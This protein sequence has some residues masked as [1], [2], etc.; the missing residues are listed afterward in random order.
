MKQKKYSSYDKEFYAIVQA[1]KKWRN[2]LMPKEF[3]LYTNNSAL[4]FISSQPKLNQIHAKWVEF[5]QN[6]TFVIEHTSGKTNNVLDALSR[7]NFLLQE[8]QVNILGFDGLKEM[9]KD[10]VYFKDVYETCENPVVSHRSQWLDYMLHE[11]LL[12]KNIKLCIPK[13]LMR[14]N[15]I[16]EKNNG[17]MSGHFGQDKTFAQENAFYFLSGMQNKETKFVEKCGICQHA[18]GRSQNKRLYQPLPIPSRPWDSINMDFVLGLPKKQRGNDSIYV[19][20]DIFSKM[21]HFVACRK[22]SDTTNIANLFF[23]RNSEITWS[24]H[25]HCLIS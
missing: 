15:L 19:V 21:A 24:T 6:F 8:I 25:K 20:V 22:T 16:K 13:C 3:F 5:M 12:F 7:I 23:S 9:Y 17:R 2:Y 1:L 11:G 10:D 18:K 4:Q 14:E